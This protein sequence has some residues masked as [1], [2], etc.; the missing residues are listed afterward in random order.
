MW[1]IRF[2]IGFVF[3]VW[4]SDGPWSVSGEKTPAPMVAET[5]TSEPGFR[6]RSVTEQQ[7]APS[8]MRKVGITNVLIDW[9]PEWHGPT[10]NPYEH[11][12]EG[13]AKLDL[14]TMRFVYSGT[15]GNLS[16]HR[17]RE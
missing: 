9:E 13:K 15:N 16:P 10:R 7:F 6:E 17:I 1:N 4:M 8:D 12:G 14:Q 3:V 11:A 2:S 5:R